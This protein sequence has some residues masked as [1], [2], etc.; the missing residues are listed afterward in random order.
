MVKALL[1]L[2]ALPGGEMKIPGDQATPPGGHVGEAAW[3]ENRAQEVGIGT[4]LFTI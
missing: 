4:Q 3:P 1:S 2:L